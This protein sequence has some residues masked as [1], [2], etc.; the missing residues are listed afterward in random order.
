MESGDRIRE[1]ITKMKS[2]VNFLEQ[3]RDD[4]GAMRVYAEEI[5]R[6]AFQ[7]IAL[8]DREH[9]SPTPFGDAG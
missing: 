9:P 8:I 4:Y 2:R 7:M 5:G 3:Q 1:I 6:L